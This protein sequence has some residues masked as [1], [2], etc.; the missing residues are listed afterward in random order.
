M[1]DW[2]CKARDPWP[3]WVCEHLCNSCGHLWAQLQNSCSNKWSCT[4]TG[5]PSA[6]QKGLILKKQSKRGNKN[7]TEVT[8]AAETASLFCT[9]NQKSCW[10]GA[11]YGS[12]HFLKNIWWMP[13]RVSADTMA[14]QVLCWGSWFRC[15]KVGSNTKGLCPGFP[16]ARVRGNICLSPTHIKLIAQ[17]PKLI[18]H[19]NQDNSPNIQIWY[20][21]DIAYSI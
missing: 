9:V 18:T 1:N 12:T 8:A 13:G 14:P 6:R 15:Y 2:F 11:P 5:N 21:L 20:P 19:K 3:L 7:G 4:Y 10:V 17:R 16:G